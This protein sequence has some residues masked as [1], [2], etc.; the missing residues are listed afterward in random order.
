MPDVVERLRSQ[1]YRVAVV[2]SGNTPAYARADVR[3]A[4]AAGAQAPPERTDLLLLD[5]SLQGLPL[6]I[7]QAQKAMRIAR[8][9][10]SIAG[11]AAGF[12]VVTSLLRNTP[13]GFS[14][15]VNTCV[16]A[17]AA[18]RALRSTPQAPGL[19]PLRPRLLPAPSG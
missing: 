17:L 11:G 4:L 15:F 2:A 9:N 12:N 5:E 8:Q 19:E 14:T 6:A 1:G 10:T 16:L 7:E 3:V 18:W 13:D